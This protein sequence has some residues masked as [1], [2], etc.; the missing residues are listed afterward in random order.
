MAVYAEPVLGV[1]IR[2]RPFEEGMAESHVTSL[3]PA[4]RPRDPGQGG[5][6]KPFDTILL[7]FYGLAFEHNIE[8]GE[9]G[10]RSEMGL[11]HGVQRLRKA[12]IY[13]PDIADAGKV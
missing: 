10:F 12:R 1:H 4:D 8:R 9:H 6:G 11:A 13:R 3:V 5:A 7:Q 2:E